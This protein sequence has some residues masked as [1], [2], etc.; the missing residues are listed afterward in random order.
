MTVLTSMTSKE[1]FERAFQK[2][3]SSKGSDKTTTDDES[4]QFNLYLYSEDMYY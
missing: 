4:S 2:A 3:T 1:E